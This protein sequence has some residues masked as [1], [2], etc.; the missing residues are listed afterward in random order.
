MEQDVIE[1]LH[2]QIDRGN[3]ETE[4]DV[5]VLGGVR[6]FTNAGDK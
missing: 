2:F 1:E 4:E 3:K 6:T 5:V